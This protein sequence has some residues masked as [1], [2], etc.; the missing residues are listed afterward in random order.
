M[1]LSVHIPKTGGVSFRNMLKEFYGPGFVL[2]YWDITDAW[3][4]VLPEIP[5]SATCVHGH[6]VAH[7]L[8]ERFPS[9]NLIT[10]VR[11]PVER[12]VSSYYHR[13]RDPDPR[14]YVSRMIHEQGLGL[15]EFAELPEARNEMAVFMGRKQ[16]ADFAFI[17]ITEYYEDAMERYCQEFGLPRQPVRRDNINPAR[18]H[19]GYALGPEVRA[20]ILAWNEIDAGIYS[21]C[22]DQFTARRKVA[23]RF[24]G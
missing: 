23:L 3:G 18:E 16:P 21:E 9:A 17:G 4:R 1:L 2:S 20:R 10:W 6:F 12:V 19:T 24:V 11:N 15:L 22:H 14:N 8:A 13:L 7:E 5:K